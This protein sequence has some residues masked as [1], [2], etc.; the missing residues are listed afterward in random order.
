MAGRAARSA[1]LNWS[2]LE[3]PANAPGEPSFDGLFKW[4]FGADWNWRNF[5]FDRTWPRSMRRSAP[6]LNDATTGDLSRFRERG[7][8][9][10][11][12]QGWADPIVGPPQTVALY[13]GLAKQFGG[14]QETQKFARLFMAPGRRPLRRRRRPNAFNSASFGSPNPPSHRCR[15]RRLHGARPIGSKTASRRR[16]SSPRNMSTTNLERA[17]R[18]SARFAPIRKRR[19]TSGG[20]DPNF[21]A[22]AT[23]PAQSKATTSEAGGVGLQAEE[24]AMKF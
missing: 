23:T 3:A 4:V 16:R 6:I 24:T 7:G 11:I 22:R 2:F 18:C 13:K 15:P 12:F 10:V 21:V 5:D 8:K 1:A 14:D 19:G 17:S 9:L 20:G